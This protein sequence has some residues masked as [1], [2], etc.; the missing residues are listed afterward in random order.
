MFTFHHVALSVSNVGKSVNFYEQ[1]GF[2]TVHSWEATDRQLSITHMRLGVMMLE[3][4]WY[5]EHQAAPESIFST[6]TDLPVIGTKHYGL[7]VDSIDE[8]KADLVAKGL[9]PVDIEIKQGRTGP[10]IFF[11]KD[12]DGILVEIAEDKR[13]FWGKS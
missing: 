1:L 7:R 12:P 2:N 10:R 6:S 5:A 9:A 13:E 4:F 8:A 11:I 3:L